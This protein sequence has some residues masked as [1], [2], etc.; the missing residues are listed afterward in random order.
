MPGFFGVVLTCPLSDDWLVLCW[1]LLLCQCGFT[2]CSKWFLFYFYFFGFPTFLII[3]NLCLLE[4][5]LW[6]SCDWDLGPKVSCGLFK[7]ILHNLSV[8]LYNNP[9]KQLLQSLSDGCKNL[10]CPVVEIQSPSPSPLLSKASGSL[11]EFSQKSASGLS[12]RAV[13]LWNS[14]LLHIL[15]RKKKITLVVPRLHFQ[16]WLTRAISLET[17]DRFPRHA[18]AKQWAEAAWS[19]ALED[20]RDLA[21]EGD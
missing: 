13:W 5:P 16:G 1:L 18:S 20:A 19:S 21:G 11:L 8:S 12:T 4:L 10:E 15:W 7:S 17:A 3:Y 2:V 6:K 14:Y 9:E